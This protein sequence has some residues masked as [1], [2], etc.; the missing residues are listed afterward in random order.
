MEMQMNA[1]STALASVL[2]SMN[3]RLGHSVVTELQPIIDAIAASMREGSGFAKRDVSVTLPAIEGQT[4]VVSVRTAQPH[5]EGLPEPSVRGLDARQLQLVN[6]AIDEKIGEPISVSMLSSIAG[7]SR[8]H[9]SHAFRR[10]VGRTP[11][12]HIVRV[13]IERAMKLMA[14]RA[15]P[16]SEIALAT[17][18]YDQAH[19]AN[20]FRRAVGM[21]PTE[22]RR[23]QQ[24]GVA[25]ASFAGAVSERYSSYIILV[26][27]IWSLDYRA[28]DDGRSRFNQRGDK[29][30]C[31]AVCGRVESGRAPFQSATQSGACSRNAVVPKQSG[32][33]TS[34]LPPYIRAQSRSTS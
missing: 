17:G 10:S 34:R 16:L 4:L 6:G 9:F 12:E 5:L 30:S 19:F 25:A 24:T 22:W 15:V 13:R 1:E 3:N 29:R 14:E 33:T 28:D 32:S 18:F 31:G 21:T 26:R 11:H 20:T 8:S 27:S 2:S 23:R 7:L